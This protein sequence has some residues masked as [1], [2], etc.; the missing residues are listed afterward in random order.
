MFAPG[1]SSTV[2]RYDFDLPAT[3]RLRELISE[4]GRMRRP[5]G[6]TPQRRGQRLNDFVAD[7]FSHWGVDPVQANV[8]SIGEIDVPFTIDGMRFL[9]EAK[10]EQAAIS[11]EP[12]AKLSRRITQRLAGTRGVFLSMSGYSDEALRD[13][14]RGQQPDML[15]LDRTHFEAMLSGLMSP[16]EL[17]TELVGRASYHGEV[18]VPLTNLVVPHDTPPLPGLAA[19]SPP[20]QALVAIETAPGVRAEVVLHGTEPRETIFDGVAV[21]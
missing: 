10:W 6:M 9:L 20:D 17:F 8:R 12:T 21:D 7:L 2:H 13:M 15:L 14:L 11:L 1:G 16:H 5:E 4:Y 3:L 19:G 18:H